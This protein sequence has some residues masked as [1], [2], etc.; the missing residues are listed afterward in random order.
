MICNALWVTK[1]AALVSGNVNPLF[2]MPNSFLFFEKSLIAKYEK[3]IT[4]P[5]Y[6]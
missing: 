5:I 1:M 4:Q 2:F 6:I 3:G